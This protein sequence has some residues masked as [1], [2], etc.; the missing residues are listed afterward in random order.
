[1]DVKVVLDTNA[2]L[3]FLRDMAADPPPAPGEWVVSV[4]T[5]IELRAN[6][7]IPPSEAAAIKSLLQK[8]PIIPLGAEVKECA[9]L[10]RSLYNVKTPDAIIAATAQ[11]LDATLMT[12]D[13]KLARISSVQQAPVRLKPQQP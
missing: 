10:I 7:N 2:V 13:K 4:I 11:V 6:L 1:M 12:N 8:T 3:Y 5:E 9:I